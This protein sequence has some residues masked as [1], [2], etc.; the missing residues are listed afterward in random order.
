MNWYI[1]CNIMMDNGKER[2]PILLFKNNSSCITK[3]TM[4]DYT[5]ATGAK[6]R[7]LPI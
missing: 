4:N 7:K 3:G 2:W 1:F 5:F 6:G